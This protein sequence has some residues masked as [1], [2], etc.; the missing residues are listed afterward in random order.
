[1]SSWPRPRGQLQPNLIKKIIN[2]IFDVART[3]ACRRKSA[4]SHLGCRERRISCAEKG[5]P[6]RVQKSV[7]FLLVVA[8]PQAGRGEPLL[9]NPVGRSN[10]LGILGLGQVTTRG[11][12]ARGPIRGLPDF[13]EKIKAGESHPWHQQG[14]QMEEVCSISCHQAHRDV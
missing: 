12:W 6:S 7:D 10:C 11:G 3:K 14:P 1:M 9:I 13:E 4:A 8:G 5:I 2:L